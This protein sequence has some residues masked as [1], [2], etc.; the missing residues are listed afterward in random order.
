MLWVGF[1]GG[2][3]IGGFI[4]LVVVSCVVVGARSDEDEVD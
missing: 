4:T 3:L 1:I 2:C